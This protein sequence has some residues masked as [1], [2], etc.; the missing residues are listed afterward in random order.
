[1]TP[2]LEIVKKNDDMSVEGT[3]S[4]QKV[5]VDPIVLEKEEKITEAEKKPD[6]N[7]IKEPEVID[8]PKPEQEPIEKNKEEAK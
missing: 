5:E 6:I 7:P 8:T 4:K 3:P 2:Q 1:M